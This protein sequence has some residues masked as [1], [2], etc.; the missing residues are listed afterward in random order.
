MSVW[1]IQS[2]E[3]TKAV[4]VELDGKT[5]DLV[6]AEPDLVGF[7]VYFSLCN[8]VR[9]SREAPMISARLSAHN[10]PDKRISL[11][12]CSPHSI[13]PHPQSLAH[14]LQDMWYLRLPIPPCRSTLLCLGTLLRFA[15][16]W[17][18]YGTTWML[19]CSLNKPRD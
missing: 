16:S 13:R 19:L 8:L 3:R 1:R 2:S 6:N 12:S 14:S 10:P 18:V 5:D 17:C 7:E 11:L 15:R 9:G 4:P